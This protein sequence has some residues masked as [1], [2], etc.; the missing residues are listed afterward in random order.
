MDYNAIKAR[1][2]AMIKA[3]SDSIISYTTVDLEGYTKKYNPSTNEDVWYLN[4]VETEAPTPTTYAGSC[5]ETVINDYF[6]AQGYVRETD[7]IFITN[8]IPK[9]A[10]G[11]KIIVNEIEYSVIHVSEI[12]PATVSILYKITARH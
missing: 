6:K 8:D 7:K 1:A 4:G 12:K 3:N 10:I 2:N 5:I 11:A 9:P